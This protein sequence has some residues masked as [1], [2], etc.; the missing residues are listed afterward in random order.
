M[1]LMLMGV[2]IETIDQPIHCKSKTARIHLLAMAAEH[3]LH[4]KLF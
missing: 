3:F 2:T 4:T 1:C